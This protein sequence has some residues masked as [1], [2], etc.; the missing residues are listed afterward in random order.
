MTRLLTAATMVFAVAAFAAPA[1]AVAKGKH[2]KDQ[3]P[4]AVD[5]YVEQVPTASGHQ[6]APTTGS[7]G[8][9]SSSV[10]LSPE[11]K[12]QLQSQGGKDT[13]VLTQVAGQAG[14]R[15]LAAVGGASQPGTLNAA[16][17]L[18]TG[19]T[20]LFALVLGTVVFVAVAGGIR[21]YRHRR[22]P[23]A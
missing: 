1:T 13:E 23:G 8:S 15:R 22:R 4:S 9:A 2:K 19:P 6:T 21:G 16:F 10:P 18:G 12:Q 17:D 14:N 11:A 5:V 7:T 3:P 20:L